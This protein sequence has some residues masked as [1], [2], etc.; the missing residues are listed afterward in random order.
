MSNIM[1]IW[2][3]FFIVFSDWLYGDF[4]E[5][6]CHDEDYQKSNNRTN[7]RDSYKILIVLHNWF[8]IMQ[9]ENCIGTNLFF[10]RKKV[11]IS[12]DEIFLFV[13]WYGKK[14]FL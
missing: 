10:Y 4:C 13:F 8:D 1:T 3:Q 14:G 6:I 7:K 11:S 5:M 12:E 9:Q 2:F